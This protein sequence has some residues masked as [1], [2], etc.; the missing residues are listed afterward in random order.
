[1]KLFKYE[2]YKVVVDPEALTLEPFK[3]IWEKDDSPDKAMATS[4]LA[5]V[6]FMCDPRSDYMYIESKEER[7]NE[8]KTAEGL[9]QKWKP[10][11][12]VKGAMDFYESFKP[13][14]ARLLDAT[15][16]MA[17]KLS[18]YLVDVDFKAT[19]TNGKP[20]YT[21]NT[22]TSTI[23][24][25]PGLIKELHEVEKA[26]ANDMEEGGKMRGQGEKA[27]FEDDIDI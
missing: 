24:Q 27:L 10:D 19:D 17:D 26:M 14:S 22:I 3:A 25:I 13:A 20:I 21:V 4:E 9:P 16:A 15:K 1:M 18:R 23:K 12:T 5:Y 11:K 6:Y 7:S 8:I 2:N